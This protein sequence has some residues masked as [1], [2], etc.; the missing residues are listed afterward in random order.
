VSL[1][2]LVTPADT[3]ETVEQ[4]SFQHKRD[5]DAI[6]AALLTQGHLV[7]DVPLDPMQTGQSDS[8]QWLVL[9]WQQHN[10]MNAAL[11]LQGSDLTKFDLSD[12]EQLQAFIGENYQEHA[13]VYQALAD[14]GVSVG[15]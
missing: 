5:H 2:G 8:Y 7:E 10:S 14:K 3:A 4:F 9:H 1:V 6:N 12:K 15:G 13:S 11:G